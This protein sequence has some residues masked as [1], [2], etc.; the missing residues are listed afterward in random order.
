RTYKLMPC[1]G[2]RT[3]MVLARGERLYAQL[4]GARRQQVVMVMQQIQQAV[5]SGNDQ[6]IA[7]CLKEADEI[8]DRLEEFQ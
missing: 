6:Q 7:K 4:L 5:G 1:G 2:I 3:Q 8:F